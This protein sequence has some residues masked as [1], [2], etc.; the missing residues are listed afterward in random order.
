[1]GTYIVRTLHTTSLCFCG[2]LGVKLDLSIREW[3][4][5]NCGAKH[6]RVGSGRSIKTKMQQEIY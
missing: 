6:G 5:I 3:E 4:C 1:M 2:F